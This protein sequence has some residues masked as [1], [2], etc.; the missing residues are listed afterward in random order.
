MEFIRE[1]SWWGGKKIREIEDGACGAADHM[2]FIRFYPIESPRSQII[3][4]F[5]ANQIISSTN[6]LLRL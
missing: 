6:P 1:E 2:E 3:S 4:F 5:S